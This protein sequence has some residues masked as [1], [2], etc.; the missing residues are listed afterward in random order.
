M[1]RCLVAAEAPARVRREPKGRSGS[2]SGGARAAPRA[3]PKV[4]IIIRHG[5]KCPQVTV[6]QF[7]HLLEGEHAAPAGDLG[8]LREL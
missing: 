8:K 3:F 7:A 4:P 6:P 5:P 2:G 1:S